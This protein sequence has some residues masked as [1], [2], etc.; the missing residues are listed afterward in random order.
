MNAI[1]A[2]WHEKSRTGRFH[3]KITVTDA[4][5]VLGRETIPAHPT[6]GLPAGLGGFI[7]ETDENRIVALLAA[8]YGRPV[9][10][11]AISKMRR[12]SQLWHQGE[13]A[14]AQFHLAFIDLPDAD[15][16]VA[17]RLFLALK[18]LESGHSPE[19]L[20]KA[21]AFKRTPLDAKKYNPDQP[22]V[23]ADNGRG[24]GQW[25]SG[26]SGSG[27]GSQD[28]LPPNRHVEIVHVNVVGATWSD[29]EPPSLVPGAQYAQASPTPII[30]PK[31][32]D[33]IIRKHGPSAPPEKGKFNAE[34]ATEE[35]IRGLIEEAWAKSTPADVAAGRWGERVVIA[36]AVFEIDPD[37]GTK[38]PYIIGRSGR[39]GSA[40]SIP[41]NSYV[42]VLDSDMNVVTCYPISPADEVNPRDE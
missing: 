40:P 16:A 10:N 1:D 7:G 24:S 35:G 41:T 33:D 26:D 2:H 39:R 11:H 36:G 21:L 30:P 27:S 8:A 37:T 25:T 28:R 12:A 6:K 17:Y 32:I 20:M 34:Y 22:R 4:G 29:T 18:V 3:P 19:A 42:V 31:T 9:A 14:L 15:E 13:K 5:V 38:I 23:P